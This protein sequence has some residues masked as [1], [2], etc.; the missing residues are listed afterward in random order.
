MR[1]TSRFVAFFLI[2]NFQIAMPSADMKK[3]ISLVIISMIK[4]EKSMIMTYL[5]FDTLS[6]LVQ[7]DN[8]V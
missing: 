3:S 8:K 6:L 2:N 7:Y 4:L 5:S 1:M